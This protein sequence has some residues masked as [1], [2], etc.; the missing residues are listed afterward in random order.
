MPLF[1]TKVEIDNEKVM[2]IVKERWGVK[3]DTVLKISQ[4]HTFAAT[5]ESKQN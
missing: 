3:I 1:E 4:N 5:I 2:Q